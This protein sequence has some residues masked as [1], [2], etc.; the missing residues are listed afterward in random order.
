MAQTELRQQRVDRPDLSTAPAAFIS[1]CGRVYMIASV[2]DQQR[3]CGEPIEDLREISRSGEALQKLLQN[4]SG[5]YEFLT[6]FDRAD[7]LAAFACIGRGNRVNSRGI[8][9][10]RL[11]PAG[12]TSVCA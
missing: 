6:G 5:G 7:Q 8:A 1:Q 4:Q 11:S 2:G 3:Q 12:P 10:S 9:T